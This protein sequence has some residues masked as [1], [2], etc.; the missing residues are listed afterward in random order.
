LTRPRMEDG[1]EVKRSI[2]EQSSA[3]IKKSRNYS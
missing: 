2:G 3:K 1:G